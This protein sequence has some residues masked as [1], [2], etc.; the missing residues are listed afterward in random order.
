MVKMAGHKAKYING[1]PNEW[2]NECV[3]IY[4][5]NGSVDCIAQSGYFLCQ[6]V[7]IWDFDYLG[8]D[9]FQGLCLWIL[10]GKTQNDIR[11][12]DSHRGPKVCTE[13]HSQV[14]SEFIL[15]LG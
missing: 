9:P 5:T 8:M 1:G 7:Y 14:E 2:M 12:H 6:G 15:F 3:F 10:R 11:M 4:C 13:N